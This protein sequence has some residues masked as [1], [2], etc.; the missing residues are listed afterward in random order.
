M[1]HVVNHST[2]F[3][4]ASELS[5]V[6]CTQETIVDMVD[7]DPQA[8]LIIVTEFSG[9]GFLIYKNGCNSTYLSGSM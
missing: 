7:S 1:Y 2:T 9:L 3:I 8:L 6:L 5:T 4:L